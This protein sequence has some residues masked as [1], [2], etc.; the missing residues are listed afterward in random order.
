MNNQY[1]ND[2]A[3]TDTSVLTRAF[4]NATNILLLAAFAPLQIQAISEQILTII[5]GLIP[6]RQYALQY[7]SWGFYNQPVNIQP[8]PFNITD[9]EYIK[10]QVQSFAGYTVNNLYRNDYVAIQTESVIPP[11]YGDDQSAGGSPGSRFNLTAS[12]AFSI[13]N[14]YTRNLGSYY[15]A[16]TVENLS[17]YGQIDS[18]KQIPIGCIHQQVHREEPYVLLQ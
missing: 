3:A 10:D 9:Y 11:Y 6:G 17:Q 8:A 4:A 1:T 16:Y 13:G 5:K 12:T 15:A 18:T 7:N 14:W 2:I